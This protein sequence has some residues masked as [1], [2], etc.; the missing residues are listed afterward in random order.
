MMQACRT[1]RETPAN[2]CQAPEK[3]NNLS[4]Q[5]GG[6]ENSRC[7][8]WITNTSVEER[9]L[10]VKFEQPLTPVKCCGR[11]V[12]VSGSL[13]HKS[14]SCMT[15]RQN[16]GRVST[17][18]TE[19]K[20]IEDAGSVELIASSRNGLTGSL[21]TP[22]DISPFI[23]GEN[24]SVEFDCYSDTSSVTSEN[25][26]SETSTQS[27]NQ[28]GSASNL[29]TANSSCYPT[30]IKL[31]DK[32]QTSGIVF[33]VYLDAFGQDKNTRITSLYLYSVLN[34]VENFSQWKQLK[35]EDT[36][37]HQNSH[38][39]EPCVRVDKETPMSDVGTGGTSAGQELKV[40]AS[41]S[42]WSSWPR[43]L[44]RDPDGD[45]EHNE[46]AAGENSHCRRIQVDR[47]I[48]GMDASDWDK[49][50]SHVSPK[51][52]NGNGVPNSTDKYKEVW[53][54]CWIKFQGRI[55]KCKEVSPKWWDGNGIP[56]T[57]HKY[58]EDRKVC[59]HETPFEERLE[60]A[61]FEETFIRQRYAW[62]LVPLR[63]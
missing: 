21:A 23:I 11:W 32:M 42:S 51:W 16:A 46:F 43:A 31:S 26:S 22:R 55:H 6:S 41:W 59:W 19:G 9:D 14:S 13:E 56:N 7:R 39:K 25:Y 54:M 57:T 34:P 63:N 29:S 3:W 61:L 18:S 12:K 5:K 8:S 38:I 62:L 40:E 30:P 24:K 60:K 58:R 52:W 49:D 33:P 44:F 36:N 53:A 17:S 28:S 15:N 47:S 50:E 1:L 2:F 35:N 20:E 4:A 27:L 37:D 48:L 45:P 10:E